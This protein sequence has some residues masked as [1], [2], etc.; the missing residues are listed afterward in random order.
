MYILNKNQHNFF[1]LVLSRWMTLNNPKKAKISPFNL[2]QEDENK[3]LD[4]KK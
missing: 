2:N 3:S 4:F 1:P